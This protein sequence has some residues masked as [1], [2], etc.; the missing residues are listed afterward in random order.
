MSICWA[1]TLSRVASTPDLPSSKI[2]VEPSFGAAF[3]FPKKIHIAVQLIEAVR[4]RG[5]EHA[6]TANPESAAQINN[7]LA[8]LL[9][10]AH[11]ST[12]PKLIFARFSA[13]HFRRR[14]AAR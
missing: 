4:C 3:K 11:P 14:D 13:Q 2:G 6:E 7:C 10:T 5:A 12:R 9:A 8:I 1:T